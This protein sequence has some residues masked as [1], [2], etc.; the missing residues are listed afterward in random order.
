MADQLVPIIT[1]AGREALISGFANADNYRFSLVAL[2][3]GT[4][5]GYLPQPD[6]DALKNEVQRVKVASVVIQDHARLHITA[7]IGTPEDKDA[8]EYNIH[9]IGFFL[10]GVGNG[11]ADVGE[12]ILFAVYATNPGGNPL[13]SKDPA[14]EL[15]LA[16]DLVLPDLVDGE[17]KFDKD[18]YLHLPDATESSAGLL[19]IATNQE[20][21][22]GEVADK[23]VSPLT[24]KDAL[25]TFKAAQ[26]EAAM[27]LAT[28]AE[29]T[30]GKAN[31]KAVSPLTLTAAFEQYSASQADVSLNTDTVEIGKKLTVGN[32][33]VGTNGVVVQDAETKKEIFFS[34]NGQIRSRDNNHRILLRRTENILELREWGNIVFSSG[35]KAGKE[36]ATAVL[37]AKGDLSVKGTVTAEKI[38]TQ[39]STYNPNHHRMYP[40]GPLVYQD[41][42]AAFK[43]GVITKLGKPSQ[44]DNNTY[45]ASKP[46]NGKPLIKFGA[47]NE[48]DGNGAKVIVPKGYDTLWVRVLGDRWT[49]MNAYFLDGKKEKLGLWSGG[50]RQDNCFC[51]D[52]SLADGRWDGGEDAVLAH[53]WVPIPVNR[54]GEVALIAKPNTG[55]NFW[56]SGVAF[57]N[58]PWKHASASA[59]T[60]HWKLNGGD[61]MKW[62]SHKWNGDI[63]AQI[64]P[65]AIRTLMIPVVGDGEDKLLY[66]IE[67]NNNWNGAMHDGITV[68][69]KDVERFMA[70]YDTPFSRHW[71]GKFYQRYMATRI[72]AALVPN[73]FSWLKVKVDMR[74]SN[75]SLYFRE[76]GTHNLVTPI[77]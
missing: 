60:L 72:P 66:L 67:H 20:V 75:N 16:F 12:P 13:L 55:K 61:A 40:E 41:I 59:V 6:M 4:G 43:K 3:D 42:H 5:D 44:F 18:S 46:W 2:G 30:A 8:T 71:N 53:Q 9:E 54:A 17:L 47:D 7:V 29:V 56:L 51:P 26:D 62:N 28:K 10:Q 33:K 31:D 48:K 21:L 34:E 27:K 64:E 15:L 76:M 74:N 65:G 14:T 69:G 49:V 52:G 37:D 25:E 68:N 1:D 11:G 32:P 58:N 57:S 38:I 77:D 35:A 22:E 50:Y 39:K 23:A 19:Q 24:L 45:P 73:G 63:L 70:T 36:T